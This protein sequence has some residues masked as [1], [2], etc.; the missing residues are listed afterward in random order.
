MGLEAIYPK[1]KTSTPGDDHKVYPYLLRELTVNKPNQVWYSD[2]TYIP[3][4]KGFMYL[5]A[6][7]DWH[8]RFVLILGFV[9]LDEHRVLLGG[10]SW[11]P[12]SL[13]KTTDL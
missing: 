8:S 6:V 9:Q 11:G 1:P 7:M 13:W 5:V 3:M 10:P 2:I 12:G 4:Y